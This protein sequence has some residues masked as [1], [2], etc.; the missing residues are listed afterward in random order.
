M[1]RSQ[2]DALHQKAAEQY[3]EGNYAAAC[4]CWRKVLQA[5]PADDKALEGLRL[6]ELLEPGGDPAAEPVDLDVLAEMAEAEPRTVSEAAPLDDEDALNLESGAVGDPLSGIAAETELHGRVQE[7]LRE[8]HAAAEAGYDDDALGILA[9]L[10]ILDEDHAE[11]REL[12]DRLRVHRARSAAEQEDLIAEGVQWLEAGRLEDARRRFAEMLE[13]VPDHAEIRHYLEVAEARCRAG[14][15][16]PGITAVPLQEIAVAQPE[17]APVELQLGGGDGAKP[18]I[19]RAPVPVNDEPA[20]AS[21]PP[22]PSRSRPI[23]LAAAGIV[24]LALAGWFGRG[25]LPGS[26]VTDSAAA[27]RQARAKIEKAGTETTALL[28]QADRLT[29]ETVGT[30]ATPPPAP[31][32]DAATAL[33]DGAAA[34]DR[35][36][37]AAAVVAFDRAAK[38]APGNPEALRRLADAGRRYRETEALR[39]ELDR[40]LRIFDEGDY[41][42]ALRILY[43]LPEGA[44]P[45]YVTRLRR[46]GWYNLAVVSLKAGEPAEAAAHLREALE[47][48]PDDAEAGRFL[49]LARRY[50]DT[51]RD[52]TYYAAVEPLEFRPTP[53]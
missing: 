41:A 37:F 34:F 9:R 17:P 48:Q 40:A 23:A 49:E 2:V 46:D 11:A 6:C 52:R 35:G 32:Q 33:A 3:L 31:A 28:A 16:D 39:T 38:L 4:A 12:E 29:A 53:R 51:P 22:R 26:G 43:R 45:A 7:L 15:R 42:G 13:E 14:D 21:A 25:F 1:E 10:F 30:D 50:A 5:D 24:V 36:D 44:D 27:D 8:A 20:V 18:R 47:V 19:R